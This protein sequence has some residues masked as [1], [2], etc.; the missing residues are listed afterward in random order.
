MNKEQLKHLCE[1]IETMEQR[2][3]IEILKIIKNSPTSIN[4]TENNN[5]CFINMDTIDNETIQ[6][7]EKYVN[8]FKQK[9]KELNE[10]E[11]KKNNLLDS[12]NE[13]DK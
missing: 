10:Q 6:H 5:G 1:T 4:I 8:F 12:L 3:H 9:E 2:E 7:I 13:L 11:L